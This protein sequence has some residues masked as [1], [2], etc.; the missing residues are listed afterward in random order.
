MATSI[1]CLYIHYNR[2]PANF[3]FI[4]FDNFVK[5][6]FNKRAVIMTNEQLVSNDE[7]FQVYIMSLIVTEDTSKVERVK[8]DKMIYYGIST[9]RFWKNLYLTD[10]YKII[11][12][13][14]SAHRNPLNSKEPKRATS[15]KKLNKFMSIFYDNIYNSNYIV[16]P[17]RLLNEYYCNETD[18]IAKYI[19]HHT[20]TTILTAI[21]HNYGYEVYSAI[22]RFVKI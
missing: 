22:K 19:E 6:I 21:L 2:S 18:E 15:Q 5:V 13:E 8:I 10:F 3:T 20:Q 11:S 1:S 7:L 17:H 4:K 16:T 9:M 12:L 14:K